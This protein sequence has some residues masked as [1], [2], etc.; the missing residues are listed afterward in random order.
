MTAWLHKIAAADWHDLCHASNVDVCAVRKSRNGYVIQADSRVC[1]QARQR[2]WGELS[3][4]ARKQFVYPEPGVPRVEDESKFDPEPPSGEIAPLDT[5]ALVV[6]EVESVD[7]VE[8]F[9]NG[10]KE[11]EKKGGGWTETALNP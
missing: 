9:N 11:F 10:R 6:L 7:Y 1:M 2:V 4:G 3:P 8:L 5:F